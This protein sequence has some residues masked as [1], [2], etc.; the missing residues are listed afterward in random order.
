M[1]P[2]MVNFLLLF[3]A[4][5]QPHSDYLIFDVKMLKHSQGVLHAGVNR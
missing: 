4:F 3:R 5:V 1:V 2:R